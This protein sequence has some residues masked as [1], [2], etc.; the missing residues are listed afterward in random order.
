MAQTVFVFDPA[1]TTAAAANDGSPAD[2]AFQIGWDHARH[3]LVPPPEHL[4]PGH[5]LREGWSA[6]R[7]CFG[8]RT[9]PL[10]SATR[11]WLQLRLLAWH[12]GRT[13]EDVQVTPHYLAQLATQRCPVTRQAVPQQGDASVERLQTQAGYAAGNLAMLSNTA[14]QARGSRD[15][16]QAMDQAELAAHHA[17][18]RAEGLAAA[19]WRRL[20]VLIS[21]VTP[22]PHAQAAALPLC[23][24]PPNRLRLLNPIQGL[25]AL[26]SLQLS[27]PD[28]RE[29]IARLVGLLRDPALRR[30][31][32][33]FFHSLLPRVWDG[34][35]PL[36]AQELRQ[37]IED[38]W[39]QPQVLRR[40]YR[41]ALHLDAERTQTLVA[42][43]AALGLGGQQQRVQV[44]AQAQA[45][46]GWSLDSGGLDLPAVQRGQG[47]AAR[48]NCYP[49]PHTALPAQ[50][51][52]SRGRMPAA[53]R[54]LLS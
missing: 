8:Q 21:M 43:A 47:Q 6:G 50:S 36:D 3:G 31:F 20:A 35:R 33:L 4:L 10:R 40:W 9:A 16:R 37:R 54:S 11:A 32:H 23:V 34:G 28:W 12:S 18:G 15:W 17:D 49:A 39:C 1:P 45:T 13:F 27:R 41:F 24:L 22:L 19:Q 30:D 51:P 26:V 25:Q 38:A 2:T 7:A 5:P 14:W 48:V 53:Q 46:D 52:A 29:R 42:R 44:H